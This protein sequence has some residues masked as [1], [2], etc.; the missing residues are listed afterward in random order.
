MSQSHEV[1]LTLTA[2][3]NPEQVTNWES[4]DGKRSERYVDCKVIPESITIFGLNPNDPDKVFEGKEAK[5]FLKSQ[6]ASNP[7]NLTVDRYNE[8]KERDR[9]AVMAEMAALIGS[10]KKADKDQ[11]AVLLA[12]LAT[13]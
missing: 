2:T 7:F 4:K 11:M 9:E 8:A 3:V 1:T 13:L 6:F 10:N 12:E 5:R